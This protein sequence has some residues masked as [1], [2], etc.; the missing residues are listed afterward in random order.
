MCQLVLRASKGHC[1]KLLLQFPGLGSPLDSLLARHQ[2]VVELEL[3][4]PERPQALPLGQPQELF[5]GHRS[6][7][8]PS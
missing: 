8:S 4:L 7:I 6:L 3:I 5:V 1:L 2:P